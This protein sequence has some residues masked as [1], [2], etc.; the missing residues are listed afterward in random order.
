MTITRENF[1]AYF[2]DYHEGALSESQVAELMDFL[3]ENPDLKPD[4][5]GFEMVVIN[6]TGDVVMPD[7]FA[8]K[9][10]EEITSWNLPDYQL[11]AFYEGGLTES[12]KKELL[13]RINSDQILKRDF[14]LYGQT[15]IKPEARIV[16]PGK[17]SLKHFSIGFYPL[18]IRQMVVAAAVIAFLAT[19][20]IY[21]PETIKEP[22]IAELKP[23]PN[24]TNND[25]STIVLPDTDSSVPQL[26]QPRRPA[27]NAITPVNVRKQESENKSTKPS[28]PAPAVTRAN[29]IAYMEP[30]KPADFNINDHRPSQIDIK[31]DFLGFSFAS[32]YTDE[33]L[34]NLEEEESGEQPD[35]SIPGKIANFVNL[36]YGT[37][38]NATVSY[39]QNLENQVSARNFGF[40]DLA[41]YGLAGVAQLTGT[42]LTIDK[43]RDENGRITS[44]GIGNLRL[45]R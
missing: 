29:A 24:I 3:V 14:E 33:M 17:S 28:T 39:A 31:Q 22:E 5:D 27:Q 8:L 12:E 38:E 6:S 16:Y 2:L 30:L 43:D 26:V 41:G 35:N 23:D 32:L 34:A 42:P 37:V 7:K 10:D 13:T 4:F 18:I 1:E 9:K 45:I 20:F 25:F 19:I 36:A 44:F 15:I 11:I 21:L 40:W